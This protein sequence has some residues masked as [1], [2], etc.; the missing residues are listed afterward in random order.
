MVC[1]HLRQL[2]WG[3]LRQLGFRV[4][5][6][7]VVTDYCEHADIDHEGTGFY[8]DWEASAMAFLQQD[9]Q[10]ESSGSRTTVVVREVYRQ[11]PYEL[12]CAWENIVRITTGL[13][14]QRWQDERFAD[15]PKEVIPCR[16]PLDS[17]PEP[18]DWL[19]LIMDRCS[20]NLSPPAPSC[21]FSWG[22][23]ACTLATRT[24]ILGMKSRAWCKIAAWR[25][26][27]M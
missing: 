25:M 2:G 7:K 16:W 17:P 19:V 13:S 23:G 9:L 11:K 4:C 20:A 3:D 12:V 5:Q 14:L 22:A 24:T 18:H 27:S 10:E 6:F 8:Q 21:S 15:K 1:G 26:S